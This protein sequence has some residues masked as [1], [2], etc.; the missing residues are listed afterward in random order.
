MSDG[1]VG[2]GGGGEEYVICFSPIKGDGGSHC[3][4]CAK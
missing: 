2:D 1:V 4:L 3:T